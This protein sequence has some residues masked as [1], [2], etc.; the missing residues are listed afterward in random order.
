VSAV[1]QHCAA[2]GHTVL[3]GAHSFSLQ[4]CIMAALLHLLHKQVWVWCR[5]RQVLL[6]WLFVWL[7]LS[8]L[9]A[10]G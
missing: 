5:A 6:L 2:S 8:A 3:L 10:V 7:V 1:A 4:H 9:S